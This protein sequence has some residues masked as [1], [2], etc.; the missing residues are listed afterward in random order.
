MEKTLYI[1]AYNSRLQLITSRTRIIEERI[2]QTE[3]E[4]I[5]SGVLKHM[6]EQV[7]ELQMDWKVHVIIR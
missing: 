4:T 6:L 5:Y 3:V 2:D 7:N 1:E